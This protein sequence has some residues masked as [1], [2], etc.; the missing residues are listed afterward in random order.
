M[1]CVVKVN[2]YNI[3]RNISNTGSESAAGKV[4]APAHPPQQSC[5][6]RSEGVVLFPGVEESPATFHIHSPEG[7]TAHIFRIIFH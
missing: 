1:S 5:L 2:G 3:A 4:L 7:S 6:Q